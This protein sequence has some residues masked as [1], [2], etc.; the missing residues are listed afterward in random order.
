VEDGPVKHVFREVVGVEVDS[1]WVSNVVRRSRQARGETIAKGVETDQVAL[2]LSGAAGW[3]LDALPPFS[4]RQDADDGESVVFETG[5][6]F[7]GLHRDA[8]RKEVMFTFFLRW[9]GNHT[10][11]VKKS[12]HHGRNC[13]YVISV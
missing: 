2:Y 11:K 4:W 13:G 10:D 9:L 6:V 1:F 3:R 12:I 7:S 8:D 5:F